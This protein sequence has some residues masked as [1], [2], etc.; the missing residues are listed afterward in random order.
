MY[1]KVELRKEK[2]E[3][4]KF[5]FTAFYLIIKFVQSDPAGGYRYSDSV[6]DMFFRSND[7]ERQYIDLTWRCLMSVE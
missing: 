3:K 5:F 7:I 6:W 4:K 1:M 2:N